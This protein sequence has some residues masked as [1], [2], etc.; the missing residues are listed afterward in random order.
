MYPICA[1]LLFFQPILLKL[2]AQ[3]LF[4]YFGIRLF[5]FPEI[6]TIYNNINSVS[7]RLFLTVHHVFELLYFRFVNSAQFFDQKLGCR[8]YKFIKF[9]PDWLA[10]F[11]FLL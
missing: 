9:E 11:C 8:T 2:S 1:E 6:L 7:F 4:G 5:S 3:L 10:L